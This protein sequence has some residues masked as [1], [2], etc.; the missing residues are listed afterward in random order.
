M[1]RKIQAKLLDTR[2]KVRDIE[3][4][5]LKGR[6]LKTMCQES[7]EPKKAKYVCKACGKEEVKEVR[8]GQEVKSCCGQP[9]EKK[10]G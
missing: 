3:K 10:E 2:R 9:M 8:Q 7:C 1:N 6:R 5:F 4:L